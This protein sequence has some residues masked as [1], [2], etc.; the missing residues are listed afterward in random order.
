MPGG[1]APSAGDS[2][3]GERQRFGAPARS[4]GFI[5][6]VR[7]ALEI[8]GLIRGSLTLELTETA[9][10][11][12]PEVMARP[13]EL[14]N[15]GVELAIDDFGTGYSSLSYLQEFPVDE[16]KIPKAFIDQGGADA[17]DLA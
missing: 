4:A 10:T 12:D 5:D 7:E 16:L 15:Q 6:D 11:R 3:V 1:S 17:E 2:A 9:F 13:G 8:S 14:R